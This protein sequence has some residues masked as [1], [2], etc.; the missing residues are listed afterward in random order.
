MENYLLLFKSLTGAQRAEKILKFN[1][2]TARISRVPG[3]IP[4]NGCTYCIRIE[5]KQLRS[6]L[7][8]L[9]NTDNSPTRVF[10][11]F[12]NGRFARFNDGLS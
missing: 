10:A 6:S 7:I 8:A 12:G 9:K 1:G 4:T 5:E 3:D 2:I 11:W